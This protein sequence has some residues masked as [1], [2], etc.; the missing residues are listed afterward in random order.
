MRKFNKI[1]FT[2]IYHK[3]YTEIYLKDFDIFIKY[4]R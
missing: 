1:N 4:K 2:K 3:N